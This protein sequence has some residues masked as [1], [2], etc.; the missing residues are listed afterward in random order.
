MEESK[1]KGLEPNMEHSDPLIRDARGVQPAGVRRPPSTIPCSG[2]ETDLNSLC[3][4][5]YHLTVQLSVH[6]ERRQISLLLGI[7][8]YQAVHFGVTF[9]IY[10][11]IL[12]LNEVLIGQKTKASEI[13]NRYERLSVEL[14]QVIIRDLAGQALSFDEPIRVSRKTRELLLKTKALMSRDVYKS[15]FNHWRPERFLRL[16]TVPVDVV[17]E[18]SGNSIRYSSYCKGYGEGGRTARRGKTPPSFE[19]DGEETPE[20]VLS[21]QL[22]AKELAQ[23]V[24][25]LVH[26]EWLKRFGAEAG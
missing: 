19:L 3:S 11:S 21:T 6:L 4:S 9:P 16:V 14:S 1:P 18:R 8:C 26:F 22:N 25:L 5:D 15:R 2:G 7:L 10:L 13:K 17:I 23:E 12:H 24:F 20:W